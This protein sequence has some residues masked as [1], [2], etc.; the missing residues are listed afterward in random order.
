MTELAIPVVGRA[1]VGSAPPV[2]MLCTSRRE[3]GMTLLELLVA[4]A[5]FAVIGSALM[6]VI[7]GAISSRAGATERKALDA[8]ARTILDRLEQDIASSFD[9]G[10]SGLVPPRFLAPPPAGRFADG[11]RVLLETTTL[12]TRGVTATDARLGGE[13]TAVLSVDRGDQAHVLWRM[14]ADGRLLRHEIR[15]PSVQPVDWG[16][17]PFEVLS[18]RAAVVLEFYEP[19]TWLESWDSTVTGVRQRRAPI[20]VRT[21]LTMDGGANTALELVSTVVVPVIETASDFERRGVQ[22]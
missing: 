19:E 8:E 21:T 13:D 1:L 9:T 16:S 14:D 3:H 22:P 4:M 11:E 20:A 7:N 2:A 17:V 10:F 5:I 12:V 6:P 18:E 15:P